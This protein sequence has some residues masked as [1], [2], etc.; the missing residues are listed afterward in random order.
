ML[1]IIGLCWAVRWVECAAMATNIQPRA[2]KHQLRVSH[3][4]LPKPFFFTFASQVEAENY[5]DALMAL[6][7]R[8]VVPVEMLAKPKTESDPMLTVVIGAYCA[9]TSVTDSDDELLAVVRVEVVGV[10]MSGVTFKWA[11]DYVRR[12]KSDKHH[13]APST[14]RKRIGSLARVVDWHIKSTTAEGV[15]PRANPLRM[16][17][18][19]YSVYSKE[20][21]KL[22]VP[23]VDVQRNRRLSP[24]D[25]ARID[26]T[27]AGVKR[28]DRERPFTDDRAFVLLYQ[29]IVDTGLRLF[30]AYRLTADS[31]DFKTNIIKVEGSKG[32]RGAI[33][34]R[35]VP[36][37][38]VLRE[39][40]K[41]WCMGRVGLIFPYWDGTTENRK[42]T[43]GKLTQRFA[44]LFDYAQVPDFTEHDLRHEAAC[45]WFELRNDRGW[46]FSDIEV[47]RI[48]GWTDT[49]MALRYASLRG[50]DL[51]ARL[52]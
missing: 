9:Q 5:R 37:K 28:D 51:S 32:H 36:I 4:L 19:G 49:R 14:I 6:L 2:G 35:V 39:P 3:K 52:G 31:F 34:P 38:L 11:E 41:D 13:L 44:G 15:I 27:L 17:T 46:V 7:E 48:M 50:E 33:K 47:C 1:L 30:E 26:A 10:R 21:A 16:M 18:R 8:G 40:L 12:L 29:V 24:E 20:D 22:V 45:R 42:K 25:C 43:Q 23:K